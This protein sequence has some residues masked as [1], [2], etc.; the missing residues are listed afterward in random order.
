MCVRI[1]R[2]TLCISWGGYV[3]LRRPGV[4]FSHV[5]VRPLRSI[6]VLCLPSTPCGVF[7]CLYV[8]CVCVCVQVIN[9]GGEIISPFDVEEAVISH[10]RVK[11]CACVCVLCVWTACTLRT[12]SSHAIMIASHTS[13]HACTPFTSPVIMTAYVSLHLALHHDATRIRFSFSSKAFCNHLSVVC[14]AGVPGLQRAT[15][16]A[17]GDGRHAHRA[18]AQ[19]TKARRQGVCV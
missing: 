17:A 13:S 10:P 4:V 16:G 19:H 5:C 11:V 15:Q 18:P 1:E 9:R 12:K 3:C 6:G 2:G 8:S 14:M 7:T